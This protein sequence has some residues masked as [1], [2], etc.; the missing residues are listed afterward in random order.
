L[1]QKNNEQIDEVKR[2]APWQLGKLQK[3]AM[4][5]SEKQLINFHKQ[6]YELDHDLKTGK[7]GTPLTIA[8]DILL[9]DI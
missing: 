5:F 3:Q 9:I 7:L 1:R 2:L 8:L 6:L 4:Q